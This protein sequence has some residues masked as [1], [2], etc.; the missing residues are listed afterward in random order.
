M[1][2]ARKDKVYRRRTRRMS[3][4]ALISQFLH[5]SR[6]MMLIMKIYFLDDTNMLEE[7]KKTNVT[8]ENNLKGKKNSSKNKIEDKKAKCK[9]K[10]DI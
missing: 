3:K 10:I 7:E 8:S 1:F 6:M 9:H 2:N 4:V 5:I